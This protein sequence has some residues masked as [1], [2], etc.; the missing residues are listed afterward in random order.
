MENIVRL[1]AYVEFIF[2]LDTGV[3]EQILYARINLRI[4]EVIKVEQKQ[5]L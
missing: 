2:F 1:R 3:V 5:I 4:I